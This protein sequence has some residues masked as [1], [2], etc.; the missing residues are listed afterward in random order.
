MSIQADHLRQ[1]SPHSN[2]SD[3]STGK[4]TGTSATESQ[5]GVVAVVVAADVKPGVH[6]LKDTIVWRPAVKPVQ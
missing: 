3:A 2:G 1:G 4:S 5:S 6:H